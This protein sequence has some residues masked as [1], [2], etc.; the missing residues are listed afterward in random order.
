[1]C[2]HLGKG[3]YKY[4][5]YFHLSSHSFLEAVCTLFLNLF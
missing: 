2:I 5:I 1:M 3:N 4:K